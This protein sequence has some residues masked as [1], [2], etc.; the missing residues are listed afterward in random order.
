M[1][2][3][4]E[5]QRHQLDI[6]IQYGLTQAHAKEYVRQTQE[7]LLL[8][9][10]LAELQTTYPQRTNVEEQLRSLLDQLRAETDATQGYGPANLIALLRLKRGNLNGLDFSKL[11]GNHFAHGLSVRL[12]LALPLKLVYH[13]PIMLQFFQQRQM[14]IS[15]NLSIGMHFSQSPFAN[16]KGSFGEWFCF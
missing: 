6:L 10:L 16:E 7:R 4:R 5:I 12:L 8:S 1:E 15:Y 11:R 13:L 9:P 14:P 3:N 2:G